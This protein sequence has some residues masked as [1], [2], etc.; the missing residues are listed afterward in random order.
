MADFNI[1]DRYQDTI[2]SI[3]ESEGLDNFPLL[4]R[5]QTLDADILQEYHVLGGQ[6]ADPNSEN[7]AIVT[8]ANIKNLTIPRGFHYS[9][10]FDDAGQL[11]QSTLTE[12]IKE[13]RNTILYT[14]E[15]HLIWGGV[16]NSLAFDSHI[17]GAMKDGLES[18]K[19]SQGV[20]DII[21]TVNNDFTT[22][23]LPRF[24][25]S[26]FKVFKGTAGGNE[27]AINPTHCL[28]IGEKE[29]N[30]VVKKDVRKNKVKIYG[31]LSVAGGFFRKGAVKIIDN[32]G[33]K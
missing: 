23:T 12:A 21:F 14:L 26:S 17:L 10:E 16:A 25:T 9:L 24:E 2:V 33:T 31:S 19:Y 20:N 30:I 28:L 1:T 4:S 18:S 32:G 13:V 22:R 29:P 11:A 6:D 3:Q 7:N 5:V 15:G 27:V 8:S